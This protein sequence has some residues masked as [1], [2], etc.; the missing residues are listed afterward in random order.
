MINVAAVA[1]GV[2]ISGLP[3]PDSLAV[4]W[5]ATYP[6]PGRPSTCEPSQALLPPYLG[7]P[8]KLLFIWHCLFRDHVFLQAAAL[9]A[10]YGELGDYTVQGAQFLFRDFAALE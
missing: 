1:P 10:A 3:A 8:Q 5:Q 9:S 6:H 2:W 4:A 7:Q